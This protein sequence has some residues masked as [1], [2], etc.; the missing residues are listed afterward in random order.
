MINTISFK[1]LRIKK[2]EDINRYSVNVT[3]DDFPPVWN[4]SMSQNPFIVK[5]RSPNNDFKLF[6]L[7]GSSIVISTLDSY[8][9]Y[10][11]SAGVRNEFGILVFGIVTDHQTDEDSKI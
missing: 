10:K 4:I 7:T 3:V 8:T 5:Y 2:I 1:D 9:L 6:N 11:F